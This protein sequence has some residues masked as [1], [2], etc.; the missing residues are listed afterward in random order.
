MHDRIGLVLARE[1]L[2]PLDQRARERPHLGALLGPGVGAIA[3]Q[4]GQRLG[5]VAQGVAH[6]ALHG[7]VERIVT[8]HQ[9]R[10]RAEL[11]HEGLG[12][13]AVHALT[14]DEQDQV[15]AEPGDLAEVRRDRIRAAVERVPRREVRE[16]V[17][18]DEHRRL[19]RLGELHR[20][21]LSA[22]PGDV[23]AEDDEGALRL[24]ELA[25]DRLDRLRARR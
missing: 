5:Q 23:V 9:Q 15:G 18:G 4:A 10:V 25:R 11:N 6:V 2:F 16:H 8:P 7:D 20:L 13:A 24:T 22:L 21:G 1:L 12:H 17:P 14:A 19:E 3:V